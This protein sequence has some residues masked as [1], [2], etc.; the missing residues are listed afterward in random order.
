MT[1][2][3]AGAAGWL[4][5]HRQRFVE[6]LSAL[7]YKPCTL[8]CY[9][10]VAL[11][12]CVAVR[13]R[14]LGVDDLDGSRIEQLRA[15]VLDTATVTARTNTGFCLDRFIKHLVAA[16]LARLPEPPPRVPTTLELLHLEYDAYLRDQRGLSDS[17]IYDCHRFMARFMTFRFGATPGN[18]DD[19]SPDDVV[20]FLCKIRNGDKPCRDKTS[21]SHLR[22]LFR[23]L[24]WSGKTKRDL[25]NAIPR[26][27]QPAQ[28]HLPRYLNPEAVEQLVG[29]VRSDDPA[30]PFSSNL[31]IQDIDMNQHQNASYAQS[32]LRHA[33]PTCDQKIRTEWP[34]MIQSADET[35]PCCCSSPASA[36]A[37]RRL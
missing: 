27:A 15:A 32:Q 3:S 30:G 7:G 17:T 14:G 4:Q 21:P 18:L 25:V 28:N 31:I 10:R 6:N 24:F 19:I 35:T 36:C 16:G 9:D 22:A 5:P 37:R 26:V 29:S 11:R 8:R 34:W 23:F 13:A 20:A 33:V 1:E 12:F 2:A